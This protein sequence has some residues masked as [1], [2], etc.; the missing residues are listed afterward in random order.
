MNVGYLSGFIS[1][2]FSESE[3]NLKD[4]SKMKKAR[5]SIGVNRKIKDGGADFI[6]VVAFGKNAENIVKF[7]SKGKGIIVKYHVQ[8]G[9]FND[10]SGK[11]IYTEDKIIDEWEFPPVKREEG[12]AHSENEQ[13]QVTTDAEHQPSAPDSDF[14]AIPDDIMGSLPF[15]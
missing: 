11:K 5:F 14:M 9:S 2:E 12:Q 3:V 4:G 13:M 10:K 1:S 6:Y 15:K 8:T 7:F